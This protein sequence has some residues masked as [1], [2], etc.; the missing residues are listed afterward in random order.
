MGDTQ[1]GCHVKAICQYVRHAMQERDCGEVCFRAV[2]GVV[3]TRI[4]GGA[5]DEHERS[6]IVEGEVDDEFQEGLPEERLA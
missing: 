5:L 1:S 6:N 4:E 2:G 3:R